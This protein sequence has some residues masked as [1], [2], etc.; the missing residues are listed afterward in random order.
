MFF[1]ILQ[2][3]VIIGG[4]PELPE[5]WVS[6]NGF[7][8]GTPSITMSIAAV[9]GSYLCSNVQQSKSKS[10]WWKS[11]K[12]SWRIGGHSDVFVT[13]S[14][15]SVEMFTILIA[16]RNSTSSK[17]CKFLLMC[18]SFQLCVCL[19]FHFCVICMFLIFIQFV[20]FVIL[21]K[22]CLFLVF[23]LI[24]WRQLPSPISLFSFPFPIN[25]LRAY[26]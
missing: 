25:L 26:L 3:P 22:R 14:K 1:F 12:V 20:L 17:F 5:L 4:T 10:S 23:S 8:I 11:L 16:F 24:L 18:L 6:V 7:Q 2:E 15:L 19:F 13:F 21:S 9:M